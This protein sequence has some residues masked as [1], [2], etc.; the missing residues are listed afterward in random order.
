M[1]MYD[2]DDDDD[3]GDDGNGNGRDRGSVGE[4]GAH[5]CFHM[6]AMRFI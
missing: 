1:M 4:N 5:A 3:D 6:L 2:D